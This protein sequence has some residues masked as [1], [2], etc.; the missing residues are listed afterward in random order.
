MDIDHDKGTINGKHAVDMI[1]REQQAQ[2]DIYAV[3]DGMS[4]DAAQRTCDWAVSRLK[5]EAQAR[6]SL[7]LVEAL[8]KKMRGQT[9]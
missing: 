2:R 9:P 3:I 1:E 4:V 5:Q 7:T 6:A 8:S